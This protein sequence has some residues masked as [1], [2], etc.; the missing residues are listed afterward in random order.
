VASVPERWRF[1]LDNEEVTLRGLSWPEAVRAFRDA[2]LGDL[3]GQADGECVS[4]EFNATDAAVLYMGRDGVILRPYFPHRQSAAQDLGPFFCG[5]CGIRVGDQAEYLSRFLLTRE[6]GLRV[7]AAVLA[8]P[9]LPAE[10]PDPQPGQPL[11][12][13][14]ESAASELEWR[15]LPSDEGKQAE[16]SSAADGGA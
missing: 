14:L 4:L 15:P 11:F 16:P 13:G 10:L 3:V 2:Q 5:G 9:P 7:F 1:S 12:P 6:D 8:G